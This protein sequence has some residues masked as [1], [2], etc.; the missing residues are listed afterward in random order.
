MKESCTDC[1]PA[2]VTSCP[3]CVCLPFFKGKRE[4]D[5]RHNFT[6]P[7]NLRLANL[8]AIT[9]AAVVAED[10]TNGSKF[11]RHFSSLIDAS[12]AWG[13]IPWL[14]SITNLPVLV[15]GI[16]AP[17]GARR[18][19]EYGADGII[20]SNHGGRQLDCV[21]SAVDVLPHVVAVA[22][23]VPVLVDGGIRRGTDIIKVKAS[24]ERS[25][26]E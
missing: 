6:L 26:T 4:A 23:Q 14:K 11:G 18:A 15:K 17:A 12:L 9:Q 16:L 25:G 13:F 10:G 3:L 21:P 20:V 19:I 8:D 24:I 1:F 22:G 5:E 7:P 2:T